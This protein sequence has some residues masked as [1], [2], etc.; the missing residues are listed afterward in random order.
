MIETDRTTSISRFDRIA[1]MRLNLCALLLAAAHVPAAGFGPA[2]RFG[3]AECHRRRV[4]PPSATF[5]PRFEATSFAPRSELPGVRSQQ[6]SVRLRLQNAI[7]SQDFTTAALLRDDLAELTSKDP[8]VVASRLRLELQEHAKRERYDEAA[9]C[10]DEL[11]SLRRFLP[12]YSLA[13]LWKGA[14]LSAAPPVAPIQPPC[15]PPPSPLPPRSSPL[16]LTRRVL[17]FALPKTVADSGARTAFRT[18][19]GILHV[20]Q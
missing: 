20:G 13:G 1:R 17:G 5:T 7:E 15:R 16:T 14:R 2:P 18:G 10:R 8:A 6:R 4:P 11:R 12:Q 19:I 9:R 3:R